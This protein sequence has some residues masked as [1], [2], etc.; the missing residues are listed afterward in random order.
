M[1][2]VKILIVFS[3]VFSFSSCKEEKS[4]YRFL[5]IG[6]AYDWEN[7]K[8]DFVDPRLAQI[9]TL[10]YDGFWLG[11]DVC[12]ETSLKP[13][14][15]DRLDELFDLK[16]PNTHFAQGN[17][18][19]RGANH[20]LYYHA[21]GRPDFYTSSFKNLVV[22]V[23]N[24]NLNSSDCESLNA[25][26]RMLEEVTDTIQ[27]ASHYV[28]MMHQQIFPELDGMEGFVSNVYFK[29]YTVNCHD[30][31]SNFEDDI[32]PRLVAL[33]KK[34][35]EVV[36]LVGDT[37]WKKGTE[38]KTDSGVDFIS[39]GINN[40]HFRL[41]RTLPLTE[42]EADRVLSFELN[43]ST[44]SLTWEFVELNKLTGVSMEEWFTK[45]APSE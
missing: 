39:S 44:R 33:E 40:S 19:Y 2:I 42:L 21:T 25:Q 38:T 3:I 6:H 27:D 4:T 17:H 24:S 23:L 31:N 41:E 8:G 34:G 26:F 36:V 30:A 22:S 18:D 10:D 13:Q 28:L 11:G 35:I 1:R 5:F 29:N 45:P 16:N 15:L 14:T 20:D 43:P 7:H 9:K 37:G 32:Y 12:A